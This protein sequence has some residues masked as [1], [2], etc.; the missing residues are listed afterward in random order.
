[1]FLFNFQN[2]RNNNI[3]VIKNYKRFFMI[4]FIKKKDIL[5]FLIPKIYIK[6]V[7]NVQKKETK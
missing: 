5:L 6:R 7:L 2:L 4:L 1:M 3:N